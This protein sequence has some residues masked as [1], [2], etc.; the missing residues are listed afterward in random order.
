MALAVPGARM[1]VNEIN[2]AISR[3]AR[4]SRPQKLCAALKKEIEHWLFLEAWDGFLPWRSEKHSHVSLFSDASG[5]AWG[6]ALSPDAITANINDY[7]D[8]TTLHAD[9]ATKETLALNNVL[10]T[11]GDTIKNSWVDAFVDSQT[12]IRSWNRQG[13]RSSSLIAALKKL[14][15]T[16]MMLNIDLHLTFVPGSQNPADAPS[17]SLRL[18]DAKLS[19]SMW[20]IVQDLFGGKRGHSV[21][22]MARPSN[23]QADLEGNPLPFFSETPLPG[24]FGVNLFAQLPGHHDRLLFQ[25][26]YVFP[27]ICLI[28]HVIKHLRTVSSYSIVVPDLLPRRFWWPL[29]HSACSSS[30]LLA[31]K[32]TVGALL[33]PTKD[34]FVS[35]WP[36]PWDLWVFRIQQ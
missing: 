25:N 16:M 30:H 34:G 9:I 36:L 13:S 19:P 18:Q 12:L 29:L 35:G 28:P 21:D 2:L 26:P 10:I 14:F 27:P 31:V 20:E 3:A 1:Y 7:W 32:G 4:S 33:R 15:N 6:G 8:A 22:L 24:A 5:F 23:V 11:F 17:R